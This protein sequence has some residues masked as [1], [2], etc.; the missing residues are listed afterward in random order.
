MGKGVGKGV[1]EFV[2]YPVKGLGRFMEG[3]S[4]SLWSANELVDAKEPVRARPKIKGALDG[5]AQ[6][7]LSLA[8]G[9]S[10]GFYDFFAKPIQGAEQEGAKGFLKGFGRGTVSFLTKPL[11]GAL[12]FAIMPAE[13]A[14]RSIRSKG[15]K[16]EETVEEE[17]VTQV[18][19]QAILTKFHEL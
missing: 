15:K 11:A 19:R 10:Y 9:V 3:M 5:T 1:G 18:E 12:D 6:G 8:K 4:E 2:Y 17:H 13:G 14:I 16:R 7:T